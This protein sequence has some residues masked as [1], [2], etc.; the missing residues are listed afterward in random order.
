M[1]IRAAA[2]VKRVAAIH[3]KRTA[4]TARGGCH[5]SAAA[6]AVDSGGLSPE[7][8]LSVQEEVFGDLGSMDQTPIQLMMPMETTLEKTGVKKSQIATAG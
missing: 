5:D 8:L 7:Q 4:A 2:L 3:V 1:K 6:F